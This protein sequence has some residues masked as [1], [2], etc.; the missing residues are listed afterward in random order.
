MVLP[1]RRLFALPFCLLMSDAFVSQRGVRQRKPVETAPAWLRMSPSDGEGSNNTALLSVRPDASTDATVA[2]ATLIPG[3]M[4]SPAE[5]SW[6]QK[7]LF[8]GIEPT[9]DIVAVVTIYFVEGA[10]G[11]ARLAQTYLLKDELHLGPAEMSAL[12]GLLVIPWTI[13]PLYGFLS[14]GFPL[15]GYQ[16]KSYLIAAG[17]VG[18]LSYAA[19]GFQGFWAGLETG[20]A[21]TGS[22][23]AMMLSSACIALSDVVADGIVVTKTRESK[24]PAIAGGLQSLCW[25]SA[26][27]GGLLSAYFSGSLIE[28]LSVRGVFSVTAVLPFLVALIALQ[29]TEQ[30]TKK[31]NAADGLVAIAEAQTK[32]V[33]EA[34]K[35]PT[36]W[37]PTLFLFLW[38]ATPTSDSAFFY[39]LSNDIGLGPEFMGRVRLV[40]SFA[41]L[42]GVFLYNQY[43]KTARIKDILLWSSIIAV[44]LGLLPILLVTHLNR[45]L[46]IPDQALIYGDDVALSVLGEIAFLPT[47]VLAAKLCPPGVEAVLFA[48]LMS[49]KNFSGTVGTELGALLT[50]LLGVTESNFDNLSLLIWI[51]NL[52]SLLPLFLIG[53]LDKVGDQS[54]AELE[55]TG[56]ALL[57][58]EER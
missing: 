6:I 33:I 54:E 53:W 28:T 16:R 12:T 48:T 24:D 44:P 1:G 11:L 23:A 39:F 3:P 36:V 13:K 46:G 41:T 29:M 51:C 18:S 27:L 19:L 49:I 25:G 45:E 2:D 34:F 40:T 4:S 37:K 20:T 57:I 35:L 42:G 14:D 31:A 43:L 8:L 55:A 15:F 50:K 47:L 5:M 38:Q 52:S 21:I 56:D 17:I 58:D 30:P 7:N 9:P 22:L 32:S 10:L 26:A